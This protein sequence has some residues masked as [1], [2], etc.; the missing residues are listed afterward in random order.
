LS[1]G[2]KI[3][4]KAIWANLETG[5]YEAILVNEAGES[6]RDEKGKCITYRGK[7]R[8]QFTPAANLDP[9]ASIPS[10]PTSTKKVAKNIPIPLFS[11]YCQHPGCVKVA[12]WMVSDEVSLPPIKV[13]KRFFSRGKTVAKR[14]YCSWH[15]VPPR[16]LDSRG[17][18][19]EIYDEAGGVRP[20]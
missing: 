3:I 7:T 15:Y 19:I 13:G 11:C 8:L 2:G 18:V 1:N 20:Q 14:Y 6:I 5:E 16:L 9:P 17:E 12:N 4:R 10:Q